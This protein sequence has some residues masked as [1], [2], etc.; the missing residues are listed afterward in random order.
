MAVGTVKEKV[1]VYIYLDKTIT[2]D[3]IRLGTNL[4]NSLEN[5][6]KSELE[7]KWKE[8][9]KQKIRT[10]NQHIAFDGLP[11]DDTDLCI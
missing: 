2:E 4:S 3:A 8:R 5:A 1:R 6:L 10:Y 7:N 11:F 9:N